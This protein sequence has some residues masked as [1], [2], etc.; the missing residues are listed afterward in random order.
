MEKKYR[1]EPYGPMIITG[2]PLQFYLRKI[3]R[4]GLYCIH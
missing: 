4:E 1:N 3:K 2:S